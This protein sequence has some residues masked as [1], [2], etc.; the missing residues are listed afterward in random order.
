VRS[1]GTSSRCS[2]SGSARRGEG[3]GRWYSGEG[4]AMIPARASTLSPRWGSLI[5]VSR[6]ACLAAI[7]GDEK[8]RGGRSL[9][10]TSSKSAFFQL[11]VR[12]CRKVP[13]GASLS[14]SPDACSLKLP[15]ESLRT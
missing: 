1:E 14:E 2:E 4:A 7:D 3:A 15:D 5:W 12:R 11:P 9:D 8:M 10:K 6:L 13:P